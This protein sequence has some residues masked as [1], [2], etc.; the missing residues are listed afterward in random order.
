MPITLLPLLAVVAATPPEPTPE[1]RWRVHAEVEPIAIRPPRR[2]LGVRE[3]LSVHTADGLAMGVGFVPH[4]VLVLGAYAGF[5]ATTGLGA[6]ARGDVARRSAEIDLHPYLELR[7]LPESR[8]QPFVAA[9][10]GAG[11]RIDTSQV[12]KTKARAHT[13]LARAGGRAGLHAFVLP[14]LSVDVGFSVMRTWSVPWPTRVPV[15][16]PPS[17]GFDTDTIGTFQRRPTQWVRIAATLG[18]S[19]WF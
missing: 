7:P 5:G 9:Q 18:V 10:G 15:L 16:V 17:F 19:G 12:G 1:P 11:Y 13:V 4:R 14:R 3:S 2:S 8:V 6:A